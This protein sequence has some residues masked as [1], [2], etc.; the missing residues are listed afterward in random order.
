MTQLIINSELRDLL[1]PLS[2]EEMA[3]LEAAILRDGCTD[4]LTVWGETIVDGHHRYAICTKHDLPFKTTQK[5]FDSLV[6]AKIWMC[7]RQDS[8]RNLTLYQRGVI[9]LKMKPVLAEKAKQNQKQSKGQ[10]KKGFPNLG[11]LKTQE[12][13][14]KRFKVSKGTLGKI[15]FLEI[16]AT[17]DI[18]QKLCSGLLTIDSEYKRLK[19]ELDAQKPSKEKKPSSTKAASDSTTTAKTATQKAETKQP[20]TKKSTPETKPEPAQKRKNIP[21]QTTTPEETA[22]DATPETVTVSLKS[23]PKVKETYCCGVKFEPDPGDDYFDWITD[24]Q[25]AELKAIQDA[26]PN[27]I[28]PQIHNFTIQNIP[29]HKPDQLINCLFFLFKPRY[30]EKLAFALLRTMA[31]TETDREIAHNVVTTLFHEFQNCSFQ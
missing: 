30:R 9:A 23:D 2:D 4:P 10:G 28:V 19:A 22:T 11:N 21:E 18:K 29:E 6:D 20:E 24:E 25:R 31:E 13:L 26:C 7:E 8:R 3:G 12:E 17:P 15:E 27:R 5:E 1:P 16:H 14:A